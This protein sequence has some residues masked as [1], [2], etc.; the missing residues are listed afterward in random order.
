[1]TTPQGQDV[2]T[3]PATSTTTTSPVDSPTAGSTPIADGLFG[4]DDSA[5]DGGSLKDTARG[6]AGTAQQEASD[7]ASTAADE[8]RHVAEEAKAKAHDLVGELRSQVDEQSKTQLQALASKLGELGDELDGLVRGD[9][10]AGGPVTDLARQLSDRS[11]SLSQRLAERQPADLLEDVRSYARRRPGTFLIGAAAAG[12][13]AGRLTR[14]AKKAE[15][16][17]GSADAGDGPSATGGVYAAD[18]AATTSADVPVG[19]NTGGR[20]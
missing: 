10:D 3:D 19:Q 1:M 14:G 13:V 11:R 7:V 5:G 4:T 17:S 16:G 8:A 20:P 18:E 15:S 9:G 6:A 2:D 12:L